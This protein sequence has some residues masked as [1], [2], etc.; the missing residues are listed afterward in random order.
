[1]DTETARLLGMVRDAL[2]GL[3]GREVSAVRTA[4]L[5]ATVQEDGREACLWLAAYLAV[6]TGDLAKGEETHPGHVGSPV[7]TQ[8]G[9]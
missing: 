9:A 3:P 5:V 2:A 1:M 8:V 4:L 6:G 7:P